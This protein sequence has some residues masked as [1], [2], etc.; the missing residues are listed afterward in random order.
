MHNGEIYIFEK[1]S[2]LLYKKT[3]ENKGHT[4]W[5]KSYFSPFELTI[6]DTSIKERELEDEEDIELYDMLLNPRQ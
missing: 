4:I 2:N 1:I 5:D 3:L 6:I